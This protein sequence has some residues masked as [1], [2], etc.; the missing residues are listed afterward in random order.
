MNSLHGIVTKKKE[1]WNNIL[2]VT[3]IVKIDQIRLVKVTVGD[4]VMGKNFPSQNVI[5]L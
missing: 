3:Y 5:C 4:C 1:K 2:E